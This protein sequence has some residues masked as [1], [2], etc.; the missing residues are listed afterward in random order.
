ML[1]LPCLDNT[2]F[3]YSGLPPSG[4]PLEAGY[5]VSRHR[6]VTAEGLPNTTNTSRGANLRWT[7]RLNGTWMFSLTAGYSQT[8]VD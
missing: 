5:S 1:R 8:E 7:Q 6:L 2:M 3:D 4:T